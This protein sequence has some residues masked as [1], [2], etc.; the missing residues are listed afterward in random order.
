MATKEEL[1][2][3]SWWNR[4]PEPP[5]KKQILSDEIQQFI[6]NQQQGWTI[7]CNDNP[8]WSALTD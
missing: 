5:A 7:D 8:Y 6:E 4:K 3:S 2:Q 1:E